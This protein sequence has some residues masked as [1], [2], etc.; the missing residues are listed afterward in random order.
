MLLIFTQKKR[1]WSRIQSFEQY[2][3]CKIRAAQYNITAPKCA[4]M[5]LYKG[6]LMMQYLLSFYVSL[7]VP[8]IKFSVEVIRYY[9]PDNN[10]NKKSVRSIS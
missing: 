1:D 8:V 6:L 5:I 10:G 7:L 9:H 2:M 4:L 3:N